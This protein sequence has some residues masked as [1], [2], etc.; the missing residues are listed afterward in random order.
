[1]AKTDIT[2]KRG[3]ELLK[4]FKYYIEKAS[5]NEPIY[6]PFE[7]KS[8]SGRTN[9]QKLDKVLRDLSLRKYWKK[10]CKLEE[11]YDKNHK[12]SS[13]DIARFE[14][15]NYQGAISDIFYGAARDVSEQIVYIYESVMHL[16]YIPIPRFPYLRDIC[17]IYEKWLEGCVKPDG[18]FVDNAMMSTQVALNKLS[19]LTSP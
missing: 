16:R 10:V 13:E 2:A 11:I 15:E 14:S 17:E 1:M 9:A 4:R 8:D 5:E 12:I 19:K 3:T 7:F 18:D 6:E